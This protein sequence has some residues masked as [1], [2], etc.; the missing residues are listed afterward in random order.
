MSRTVRANLCESALARSAFAVQVLGERKA[1]CC[2][3]AAVGPSRA[4]PDGG[5]EVAW[6]LRSDEDWIWHG[7]ATSAVETL[8]RACWRASRLRLRPFGHPAGRRVLTCSCYV[9]ALRRVTIALNVPAVWPGAPGEADSVLPGSSAANYGLSTERPRRAGLISSSRREALGRLG[10]CPLYSP[11]V[12][13]LE[14][15]TA[16]AAAVVAIVLV[17]LF[18]IGVV[19][20]AIDIVG[21]L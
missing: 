20:T 10:S 3:H 15:V 11:A 18:L 9:P 2:R 6:D 13:R 19:L 16:W 8:I 12:A 14:D 1:D 4:T 5:S 17:A 21:A 7:A